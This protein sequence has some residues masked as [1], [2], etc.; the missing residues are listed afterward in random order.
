MQNG[1]NSSCLFLHI[2]FT[3]RS[4]MEVW[5]Q[6]KRTR[7]LL[8]QRFVAFPMDIIYIAFYARRANT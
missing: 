7:T 1:E 6:T 8:N 2:D 4:Q 3:K 5:Q